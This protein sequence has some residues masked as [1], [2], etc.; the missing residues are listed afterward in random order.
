MLDMVDPDGKLKTVDPERFAALTQGSDSVVAIVESAVDRGAG[1]YLLNARAAQVLAAIRAPH[2][3]YEDADAEPFRIAR[4]MYAGFNH[5]KSRLYIAPQQFNHKIEAYLQQDKPHKDMLHYDAFYS[6]VI[7]AGKAVD[8]KLFASMGLAAS[9][10]DLRDF[11]FL[12]SAPIREQIKKD[13]EI[14]LAGLTLSEQFELLQ[15]LKVVEKKDASPLLLQATRQ[16]RKIGALRLDLIRDGSYEAVDGAQ[17]SPLDVDTMRAL[18]ETRYEG[19]YPD[20]ELEELREGLD[21]ALASPHARFYVFRKGHEIVSF[22][23]FEDLAAS[24]DAAKYM[25]SFMTDPRFDGGALGQALLETALQAELKRGPLYAICDPGL[26][27]FYEK[28][29][30]K[31]ARTYTDDHGVPTCDIVLEPSPESVREAA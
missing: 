16:L 6:S 23:R 11:Y 13:F 17:L 22:V 3:E 14:E 21:A 10:Q 31:L 4:D 25:G 7:D 9:E 2:L 19:R 24:N 15:F 20:A 29:G 18:H 5:D 30:F 8:T 27:S 1:S 12:Q 28:F 26:V